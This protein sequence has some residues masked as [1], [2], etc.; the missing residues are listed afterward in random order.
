MG[1]GGAAGGRGHGKDARTH[2]EVQV[3]ASLEVHW[4]LT[5]ELTSLKIL[6]TRV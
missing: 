6:V 5:T 1:G 3:D 4:Q 2:V